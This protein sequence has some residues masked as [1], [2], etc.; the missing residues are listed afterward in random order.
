MTLGYN[1]E[2]AFYHLSYYLSSELK[3]ADDT[4][5]QKGSGFQVDIGWK[6]KIRRSIY[7][8]PQMT[9]RKLSYTE[10]AI[11]SSETEVDSSDFGEFIPQIGLMYE[12]E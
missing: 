5:F 7:F 11:G 2:R 4:T 12:Y 3:Y 9:Y 1:D 8:I 10:V 6:M